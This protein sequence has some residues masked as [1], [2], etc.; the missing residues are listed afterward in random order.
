MAEENNNEYDI[1][2]DNIKK[3][4][5]I[6][7]KFFYIIIILMINISTVFSNSYSYI[8]DFLIRDSYDN[9]IYRVR[10][11]DH[12]QYKEQDVYDLS[13]FKRFCLLFEKNKIDFDL[14]DETKNKI[15]GIINFNDKGYLS[16]DYY[17]K[18]QKNTVF[19]NLELFKNTNFLFK[20]SDSMICNVIQ[21]FIKNTVIYEDRNIL[22]TELKYGDKTD[23]ITQTF[24]KI[25][26]SL[27]NNNMK[28]KDLVLLLNSNICNLDDLDKVDFSKFSLVLTDG[29]LEEK[30]F[31]IDEYLN[32]K[33]LYEGIAENELKK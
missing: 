32:F 15:K 5:E 13:L 7:N 25:Q 23:N 2:Y 24:K 14:T 8:K 11:L 27:K 3:C 18:N 4:I 26:N 22:Y 28:L 17:D 30:I 9:L 19:I 10:Y 6:F 29:D 12:V 31:K 1:L 33:T 20:H 21:N 16:I